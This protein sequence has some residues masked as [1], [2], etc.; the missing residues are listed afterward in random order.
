MEI[1]EPVTNVSVLWCKIKDTSIKATKLKEYLTQFGIH[2]LPGTYFFWNDK[3][4]GEHYIRIALA[5]N[6]EVLEPGLQ[7]LRKAIDEYKPD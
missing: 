1:V 4:I 3:E 2:V 6:T 7:A 5:R